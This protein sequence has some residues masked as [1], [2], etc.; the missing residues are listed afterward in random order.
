M[1]SLHTM[2]GVLDSHCI[3]LYIYIGLRPNR[4][5]LIFTTFS[6]VV[7][8][9]WYQSLG[10]LGFVELPYGDDS[11]RSL[12]SAATVISLEEVPAVVLFSGNSSQKFSSVISFEEVSAATVLLLPRLPG[13]PQ[14]PVIVDASRDSGSIRSPPRR[15][16]LEVKTARSRCL[17]GIEIGRAHV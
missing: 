10:F 12:V 3:V 4:A 1:Y 5:E 16:V 2:L 13:P 11:W 14:R 15:L 8:L 7:F 9:S 17:Q 6:L